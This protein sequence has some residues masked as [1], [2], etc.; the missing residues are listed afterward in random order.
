MSLHIFSVGGETFAVNPVTMLFAKVDGSTPAN[1]GSP[2]AVLDLKGREPLVAP[3]DSVVLMLTYACNMACRY[4]R[5]GE[6]PDV[7]GVEMPEEIG[8][9]AIDWLAGIPGPERCMS[10]G[11]FGGEPFLKF[12]LMKRMAA[13]AF[14]VATRR[15]R[16]LKLGAMTNGLVLT[17]EVIDFVAETG[18]QLTVSFD[19]PAHVQDACRVLKNGGPSHAL[20]A[21][22]LRELTR[23]CPG[24]TV[25]PT[26]FGD[27][28]LDEVLHACR[29]LGFAS[30]RLVKVSSSMTP[31][32]VKNDEAHAADSFIAHFRRQAARLLAAVAARDVNGVK[33][34]SFD[35]AFIEVVRQALEAAE[36]LT[37]PRRRWFACGSGQSFIT[38]DIKGTIHP[39]PRFLARP[40]YRMGSV[41]TGEFSHGDMAKSPLLH[42]RECPDCW[43]R[44]FCGG[45]CVV[46]HMGGSGSMFRANPDVCRL[47]KALFEQGI[48]VAASLDEDDH[49]FLTRLLAR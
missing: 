24:L 48:R 47:R 37:P 36:P 43:A 28:D 6:I 20:I 8:R 19:G 11:F 26:V 46:E 13:Y 16:P 4:C 17:D 44:Y 39:C 38:V 49:A 29:E 33:A 34:V 22:R 1:L 14:E 9:R 42:R 21:P 27:Q 18:M 3:P 45:G 15:G 41:L 40:E 30:C 23:R 2:D 12:G 7:E 31:E 10:V 25:R 5:Q 35:A 32:G